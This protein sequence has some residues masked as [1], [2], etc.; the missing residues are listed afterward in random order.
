MAADLSARMFR[1]PTPLE[2]KQLDA[3]ARLRGFDGHGLQRRF[4]WSRLLAIPFLYWSSL[5]AVNPAT[6]GPSYG[7]GSFAERLRANGID[8]LC[9]VF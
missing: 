5:K 7:T 6:N 4:R 2:S 1:Q 8:R 9:G 3:L